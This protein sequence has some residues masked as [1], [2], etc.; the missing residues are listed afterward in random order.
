[1]KRLPFLALLLLCGCATLT[2]TSSAQQT[3]D[4]SVKIAASVNDAVILTGNS[5]LSSGTITPSQ[6]KKILS[7]TD[8]VTALLT[9]ANTAFAAGNSALANSDLSIANANALRTQNCMSMTQTALSNCLTPIG[10][11]P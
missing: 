8:N 7:I 9:A 4:T 5:L 11:T 1:M 3:W 6:A 10:T 2:G